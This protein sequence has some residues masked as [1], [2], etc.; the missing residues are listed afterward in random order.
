MGAAE[1]Q[2]AAMEAHIADQVA[3]ERLM[4][5]HRFAEQRVEAQ[6]IL[7]HAREDLRMAVADERIQ[8]ERSHR[9]TVLLE[10][11]CHVYEEAKVRVSHS[12]QEHAEAQLNYRSNLEEQEAL[13]ARR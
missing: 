5:Q 1:S 3:K 11:A 12:Q 10:K 13:A 7:Q 8:A 4:D 6:R 2:R 9:L